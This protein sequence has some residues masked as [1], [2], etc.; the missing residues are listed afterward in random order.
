MSARSGI[1]NTLYKL[2]WGTDRRDIEYIKEAY[3]ADALWTREGT[4][5]KEKLVLEGRDAIVAHLTK[6]WA[7]TPQPNSKHAITNILIENESDSEAVVRSYKTVVRIDDGVPVVASSGW[8]DDVF[9]NDGGT[10]RIKERV[11]LPDGQI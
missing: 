11:L 3:A 9:V 4:A 10:W 1:E 7:S 8:Y 6:T 2:A 5:G